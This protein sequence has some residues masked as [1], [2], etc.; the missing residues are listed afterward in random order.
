[1]FFVQVGSDQL[2]SCVGSFVFRELDTVNANLIFIKF[3]V[4]YILH[5]FDAC[6]TFDQVVKRSSSQSPCYDFFHFQ[7]QVHDKFEH[8][9]QDFTI[10]VQGG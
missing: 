2:H 9:P 8:S 4:D 3:F 5:R 10:A 6:W 1:M 7:E